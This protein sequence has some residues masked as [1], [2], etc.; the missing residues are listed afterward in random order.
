MPTIHEKVAERLSDI[1]PAVTDKVV[2]LLVDKEVN[3]RVDN[4]TQ[5]LAKLDDLE[6]ERRKHSKPDVQTYKE[7]LS[8][9]DPQF[10]K[11]RVDAIQKLNQKIE[12]L[13]KA[14]DKAID[15]GDFGDLNN[16]LH[17]KGD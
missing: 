12:K 16:L 7:D 11:E 6:K 8:P 5:G 3:K 14:L 15:A 17:N 4:I 2:D 1:S 10:S 9:A 13:T